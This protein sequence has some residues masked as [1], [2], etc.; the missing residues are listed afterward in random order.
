MKKIILPVV[1][2]VATSAFFAS[3]SHNS[4]I[5]KP[6]TKDTTKKVAAKADADTV[7]TPVTYP[8]IDKHLYDSL[9]KKL[10]AGDTTGRWPVKKSTISL[11]WR[12]FAI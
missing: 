1:L 5:A 10:A 9:M 4:T 11:A 3:C 7:I 2:F 6:A 8:P 12:H